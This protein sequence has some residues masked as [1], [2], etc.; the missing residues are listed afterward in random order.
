[1][2][3][4][5]QFVVLMLLPALSALVHIAYAQND[6]SPFTG[7]P[8]F[9]R[10]FDKEGLSRSGFHCAI[11]DDTGFLWFGTAD[12]VLRYDGYS[13]KAFRYDSAR[14]DSL[15][16]NTV[17]AMIE[18]RQGRIWVGTTGGGLNKFNPDTET[19]TRYQHDPDNPQS[20]SHNGVIALLED[21]EGNLWLGTEGGGLNAFNPETETFT[22][23]Q[24]DPDN[25][26]SLSQNTTWFLYEDREGFI[27]AATWGKGLNRFDPQT[28]TFRHYRHDP[29]DAQSLASDRVAAIHEDLQGNVWVAGPGGLNKLDRSTGTFT[30]HTGDPADPYSLGRVGVWAMYP[31]RDGSLWLGSFGGGLK[32]FNPRTGQIKQY[33]HDPNN[34]KSL[35]SD[36]VWCVLQDAGGILWIGTVSGLNTFNPRTEA[37]GYYTAD[38]N[39]PV[40]LTSSHI[41]AIAE[42][43]TGALWLGGT[44][45]GVQKFDRAT[46]TVTQYPQEP[47]SPNS[48]SP[49]TESLLVD[50]AGIIWHGTYSR[51]LDRFDPQTGV[52]THYRHDSKDALTISDNRVVEIFEDRGGTLWI[53]TLNGLNRLDRQREQFARYVHDP[54]DPQSISDN[55]IWEIYE[56]RAG[57]LWI[58]TYNGLNKK[59]PGSEHFERYVFDPQNPNS[60]SH[61]SVFTVLENPVGMLWI[62]TGGGL[63]RMD[64]QTNS[65]T[66]FTEKDGLPSDSIQCILEHE[67][68]LWLSTKRGLSQFSPNPPRFKNYNA[69]DGLQGNDFSRACAGLSSGELVFGGF[70]GI[71]IF[72]PD[73]ITDNTHVPPVVLTNFSILNTPVS[74]NQA[75]QELTSLDLSYKDSVFAF[76]FCALDYADPDKNRYAYMLEGFDREWTHVDGSRRFATYTNL[77]PGHYVFRVKGSNNDG[78]WNEDGL[79]V[80][81]VI[82]PPWWE[83]IW[84]R[85]ATLVLIIGLAIAGVRGRVNAVGRQ[86]HHLE[87]Q[88]AE[89]TQALQQEVRERERTEQTIREQNSFLQTIL[90]SLA[91]PF[92]VINAENYRVEMANAAAYTGRLRG[93]LTCYALTHRGNSPC[94][95]RGAFCP[96]VEVKKTKKPVT[97]EHVHV[98]KSGNPRNIEVHG[99]P[100]FDE[101]GK[102]VQIIEYSLDI[103]ERKRI[104]AEL[105]KRSHDLGR[106]VKE[107]D[108]LYGISQLLGN[109]DVSLHEILQD[110][111]NLIP[112]SWQDPDITCARIVVEGQEFKTES[113]RESVWKQHSHIVADGQQVGLVEVSYMGEQP[114]SA[115]GHFLLEERNLLDAIAQQLGRIVEYKW[116][117]MALQEAKESAEA[118]NRTKSAF[119]ANMSHELRT[120]LNA[121]LGF[122]QV[123]SHSTH[124]SSKEQENLGII[125]RNGEFLLTLINQVLDLSK[126]EAGRIALNESDFDLYRLFDELEDMFRLHTNNKGLHLIVDRRPDLPHFVWTDEVKLRQVL[127]NLLNNAMKF[128]QEGGVKLEVAKVTKMEEEEL[129]SQILNLKFQISDTGLGM[130]PEE[131]EHLFEAFVQTKTGQALQEGTG[132]GLI[133]SRK[134][135][136]LMGGDIQVE[137]E[138]GR[139]TIVTFD[140]HA[141][142][143]EAA[144]L[145][146]KQ[147]ARR[148]LALEPK[149]PRYRILVVDDKRDS[150]EVLT[151]LL[152]LYNF[153]LREAKN[154]QEALALWKE[155]EPHLIFMDMRMPDMDGYEATRRI[156]APGVPNPQPSESSP[157]FPVIIAITASAFEENRVK[158]LEAGCDDFIR[159]PFQET[160]IFDMLHE[161]LGVRFVYEEREQG[162]EQEVLTPA[163]LAALPEEWRATLTQGAEETDVKM[164][165]TVIEQIRE[166][167]VA[168][169][170]ALTRLTDNFEY[171]EIL[172]NLQTE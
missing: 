112:P 117:E 72:L 76:E 131:L 119:L 152:E 75:L 43:R 137:S 114:A 138:V 50:R 42:E 128:T 30:R 109:P 9:E 2:K 37:F 86:K 85:V 105:Q 70:D 151:T 165:R 156:R 44:E 41:A 100:L 65:F 87:A 14:D 73:R 89:R 103:T 147:A 99:F 39:A 55:A 126:I 29:D 149:Q 150:R 40:S 83:T 18:D 108:C 58:G 38:P 12:G 97:I 17:Y 59:P 127:I 81:I 26:E 84:F 25:P 168:V 80:D 46:G 94:A 78:V 142:V 133:I 101:K 118:A 23:Y 77:D 135:V 143:V 82:T 157:Q 15:S 172:R 120:P 141:A 170:D 21:R 62:G 155:W 88:V 68:N 54:D 145:G 123:L 110:T 160:E 129:K 167:D 32:K 102:V 107:L 31:D 121:I 164:L 66:R 122:S 159:K 19:F 79:S 13:L 113:F 27:W 111:V 153:E 139:G 48:L 171:D 90:D 1:M 166:C 92:Y 116:A 20:L 134:F 104:E 140:I 144:D 91:Y 146:V 53:G 52:V 49:G 67:G 136:Q 148:V 61:N 130:T 98:D 4:I 96:L 69:K 22:R 95:D 56:D 106:R 16:S 93:D 5:C 35:S 7:L 71:N 10:L 45:G 57:N 169:A 161:Y 34:P 154:G 24:H 63:T 74:L 6:A 163:A 28:K 124:L 11:Q 158:V 51:G 36:L 115:E 132:L 8:R 47:D 60:L 64:P 33:T 3:K 125:R 162:A